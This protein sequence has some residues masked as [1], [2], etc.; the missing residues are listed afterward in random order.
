MFKKVLMTAIVSASA[1]SVMAANAA[2]PGIYMTGQLGYANTHMGNKTNVDYVDQF[3]FQTKAN[4]LSNNGLAGRLALGYQFTPNFAVEMGYLQLR[5]DKAD[6]ILYGEP[7]A[8]LSLGQH[9]IDLAGKASLP[10]A[11]NVNVYGKLGVAYLTTNVQLDTTLKNVPTT[12]DI[13]NVLG[14]AKHRLAP[15]TAIGVSYNVTPSFSVDTSW[16]HIQP[17]GHNRPGNI[18][19]AAVGFGY[20]FG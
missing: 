16:T 6:G 2:V 14:I 10:V 12:Y 3:G 19:F 1:L 18:D 20:T 13:N 5:K 17:V 9:A 4:N 8:T 7:P 11:N 15:E